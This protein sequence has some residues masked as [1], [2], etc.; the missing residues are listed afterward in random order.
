[1]AQKE[2]V[3]GLKEVAIENTVQEYRLKMAGQKVKPATP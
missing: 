1:M 2:P 3:L